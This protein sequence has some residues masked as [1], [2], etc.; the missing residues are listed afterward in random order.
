M[1]RPTNKEFEA[2]HVVIDPVGMLE[3]L[4]RWLKL[5][6]TSRQHRAG[7]QIDE[8]ERW[9]LW[10]CIAYLGLHAVDMCWIVWFTVVLRVKRTWQR[11]WGKYSLQVCAGLEANN[12]LVGIALLLLP[13][14][15]LEPCQVV[16]KLTEGMTPLITWSWF[17]HMTR[18]PP[19]TEKP[20][21]NV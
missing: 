13:S 3:W 10:V 1:Y 15:K 4:L 20:L 9:F 16:S 5:K 21:L 14:G 6:K 18:K 7:W 17:C 2:W 11:Y 12:F 8:L 19:S